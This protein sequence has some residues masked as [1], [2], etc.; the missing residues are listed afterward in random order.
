MERIYVLSDNQYFSLGISYLHGNKSICMLSPKDVI[1]GKMILKGG[2]CYVYIENVI[3]YSRVCQL[4][5]L[6]DCHLVFFFKIEPAHNKKNTFPMHVYSSKMAVTD[7]VRNF[8]SSGEYLNN[9]TKTLTKIRKKHIISASNGLDNYERWV[10][11]RSRSLNPQVIR[12]HYRTLMVSVGLNRISA[13][14]RLFAEKLS[15]AY[16]IINGTMSN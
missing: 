8:V 15:Q 14:N 1:N 10:L 3:S 2:V 9:R 13:Y 5:R 4:L 6:E 11:R 16:A 12:N 7:F